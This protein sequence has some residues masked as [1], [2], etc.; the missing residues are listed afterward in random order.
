M[1]KKKENWSYS[2]LAEQ[3]IEVCASCG[4]A[5]VNTNW[6]IKINSLPID[7]CFDCLHNEGTMTCMPNDDV[8]YSKAKET[9]N[10]L[11]GLTM[12]EEKKS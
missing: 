1:I 11:K 5:N 6:K 4:G 3:G 8:F 2:E 10:K 12:K 9:L 7:W